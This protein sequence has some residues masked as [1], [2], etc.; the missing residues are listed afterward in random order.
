MTIINGKSLHDIRIRK[1]LTQEQVA[2]LCGIRRPY[3]TMIEQG[4]RRPSVIVAQKI[5]A[6]LGFDWTIFFTQD[7][8]VSLPRAVGFKA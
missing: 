6:V 1:G 7:G 3:Y 8:N 2:D 4:K 5:G